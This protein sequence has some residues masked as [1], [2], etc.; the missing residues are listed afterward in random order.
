MPSG[1]DM[2]G[3][4]VTRKVNKRGFEGPECI[5][6]LPEQQEELGLEW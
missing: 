1:M 5:A 6:R 3:W 4:P 2:E